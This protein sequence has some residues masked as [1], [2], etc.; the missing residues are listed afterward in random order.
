M[1]ECNNVESIETPTQ[2]KCAYTTT[3]LI[4]INRVTKISDLYVFFKEQEEEELFT[5]K[6]KAF[7][8]YLRNC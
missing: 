7:S 5:V 8:G 1:Y 2:I 4:K 6:S 3:E